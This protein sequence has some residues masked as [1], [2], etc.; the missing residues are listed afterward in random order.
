MRFALAL[1]LLA[2]AGP[3]WGQYKDS[4]CDCA[5]EDMKPAPG[6]H[7]SDGERVFRETR[8][9]LQKEYVDEKLADDDL[10]RAAVRGLLRGAGGRNWDSLLSPR[11]YASLH[12]QLAGQLV[13]IGVEL[14]VEKMDADPG[15]LPVVG[16]MP[17]SPAERAGIVAGDRLIKINDHP[18]RGRPAMES[19]VEM[20]GAAGSMLTLTVLH[21]DQLV[22]KTI[23]R[24]AVQLPVVSDL[25]LPDG[26][27][28]VR[29]TSFNERTAALL[30]ASLEKVQ[31]AKPRALVIDLRGNEGG[32]L[33]KAIDCAGLLLPKGA[34]MVT[35]VGRGGHETP[36]KTATDPVV[37]GVPLIALV[38][39]TT[40]S[41][42]ELLAGALRDQLGARL[43]GGRTHGKW[44]VQKIVELSN[45]YAVKYT[46]GTFKTPRGLLPDGKGLDPDVDV[47]M[48]H[49]DVD[50]AQRLRDT[51]AR[52]QADAQ[53][54]AALALLKR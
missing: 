11:E 3:A 29:V 47:H 31:A 32:L 36:L 15:M 12:N 41:S 42:A 19:L 5:S 16:V 30:R 43:V 27:S 38:D 49:L 2:F 25:Q 7:F 24:E 10:W 18:V 45:G 40:S 37:H 22:V 39:E 14:N 9:L 51:T 52:V 53:L 4:K 46:I 17:G 23:K 28:L 26:I 35:Q 33:D 13:G 21:E 34:V 50:R 48:E 8:A 6:E 44:N 1:S 20:R 54:R